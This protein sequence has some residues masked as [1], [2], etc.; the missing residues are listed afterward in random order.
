MGITR[1]SLWKDP[2]N[3]RT[4][5]GAPRAGLAAAWPHLP[6]FSS[7]N[8]LG[9][10]LPRSNSERLSDALHPPSLALSETLTELP[11]AVPRCLLGSLSETLTELPEAV[12]RCLLGS[13]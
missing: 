13:W 9:E 2:M 11:E 7:A 12:P 6:V 8:G 3:L 4:K 10:C 1:L 5:P